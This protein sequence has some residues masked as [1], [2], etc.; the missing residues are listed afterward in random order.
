M[1]INLRKSP[2]MI[3]PAETITKSLLSLLLLFAISRAQGL[4]HDLEKIGPTIPI[5]SCTKKQ[6]SKQD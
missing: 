1:Y 2:G 3:T 6:K 4:T 5:N